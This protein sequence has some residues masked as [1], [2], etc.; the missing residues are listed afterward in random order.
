MD[1]SKGLSYFFL[2]LGV[3]VALGMVFAPQAGAETRGLLRNKAQ[4]GGDYIRRRGE[5]LRESASGV[6]ERSREYVDRQRDQV[7]A[8]MQAGK[9]AY[10][11][12]IG[13]ETPPQPGTTPQ[14]M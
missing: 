4:E 3:G 11:E 2:G 5:E 8:A 1:E 14:G 12:M 6:V 13:G 7:N 9:Q 10:R